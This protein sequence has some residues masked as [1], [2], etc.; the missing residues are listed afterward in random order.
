MTVRTAR[1][2]RRLLNLDTDRREASSNL[3]NLL[4]Y[5]ENGKCGGHGFVDAPGGHEHQAKIQEFLA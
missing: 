1:L 3:A 2:D 5:S 4:V